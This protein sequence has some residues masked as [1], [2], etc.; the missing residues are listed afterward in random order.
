MSAI[1][2]IAATFATSWI[3]SGA[4]TLAVPKIAAMLGWGKVAAK[5][6]SV[7][8]KVISGVESVT[9]NETVS[10]VVAMAIDHTLVTNTNLTAGDKEALESVGRLF[11]RKK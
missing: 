5:A 4:L 1:L 11:G 2:A 9:G 10:K 8:G 3:G 6:V 7:G